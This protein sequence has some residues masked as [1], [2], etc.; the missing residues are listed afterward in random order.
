M[1]QFSSS[2]IEEQ[3][4]SDVKPGDGFY[5]AVEWAYAQGITAGIK[6]TTKFAPNDPCTRG[7]IAMFLWRYAGKPE[8]SSAK[9][10]FSDVKPGD[11]FFRAVSWAAENGITKGIKGTDRFGVNDSCTR[12]QCVTFLYRLASE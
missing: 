8:P 11:G 1:N 5:R 4:F 3:T 6:G 7:Q 9:Q 2:I 10:A 12:A